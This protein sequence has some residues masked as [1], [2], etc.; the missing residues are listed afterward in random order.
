MV[1]SIYYARRQS[2]F[3]LSF[4]SEETQVFFSTALNRFSG[5]EAGRD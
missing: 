5:T 3:W 2:S 1:F 4:T